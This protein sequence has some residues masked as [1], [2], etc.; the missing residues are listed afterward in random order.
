MNDNA[1]RDL[2]KAPARPADPASETAADKRTET[3]VRSGEQFDGGTDEDERA[4]AG[5]GEGDDARRVREKR[6]LPD[7]N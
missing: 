5:F 3:A 1:E 4:G 6:G 7:P 2:P